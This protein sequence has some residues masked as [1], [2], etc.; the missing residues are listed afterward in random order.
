[1]ARRDEHKGV[2][3]K[4][5]LYLGMF[6]AS[7]GFYAQD[8]PDLTAPISGSMNIPVNTT[9]NWESITGVTGY[10]ISIGTTPEGTDIIDRRNVGSATTYTPPLGLPENT[11]L[12]VTITLFF[13]GNVPEVTCQSETFRTEDVTTPP[14]C[15]LLSNPVDGATGVNIANNISWQYSPRATGYIVSAGTTP[16][17]TDIVNDIDVGNTLTYNP[18]TNLP[19]STTVY[20]RITPYNEN[21]PTPLC[22]EFSFTT[23]AAA[24][25]PSCTS[26]I[27]PADGAINVPLTP[28]LE[29]TVVPNA[30]G[31]RVSIGTSPLTPNILD[32]G[33]FTN[34]STFVLDFEP[35]RTFFI[36]IVPFN[37]AG[38][39]IGCVQESFSTVLGCGPY[40]DAIT[41]ELTF[42]N[43]EIDFPDEIGICLNED[44]TIITAT[45]TAEGYRWFR[46][47]PGSSETLISSSATVDLTEPGQYIYEAYNTVSQSGVTIECPTIKEFNVVISEA[48]TIDDVFVTEDGNDIR[49]ETTVSGIGSYE[50][51]LDDI[52]GSYQDSNVFN[53]ISPGT[54]TIYVRD[55]NGCG[56]DE[57]TIFKD[58]TLEGFP[59]FFTPNGDGINDYWQF[60][61]SLE[62]G[63]IPVEVIQIFDRFGSLLAQIDPQSLGWD[64]QF[65]NKP[66][67]SSDY[68]FKATSFNQKTISGHFSLKR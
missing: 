57:E 38:D 2:M 62:T 66:L 18:P 35:N 20:V 7:I 34:N 44:S 64:G 32:N 40:F 50:Y 68:W 39:A 58:L 25:L 52:D 37:T 63:E 12:Y 48:P 33:V 67:P 46:L 65:N 16:G 30:A 49:I 15:T 10:F 11:Q 53:N 27:S 61:P 19:P 47:G 6:L 51:A 43:P 45:D 1:M 14:G 17:G 41:G 54:H 28:F 56:M 13:L 26:L 8:C 60:V 24:T 59:K 23:G 31:Y 9:I 4:L 55:K 42:I 29:W 5:I 36:T 21:N 3:R 22:T